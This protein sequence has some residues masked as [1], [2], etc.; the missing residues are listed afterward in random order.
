[1]ERDYM[2]VSKL[3][4]ATMK[5]AQITKIGV[6]ITMRS[7]ITDADLPTT[8]IPHFD[9]LTAAKRP[10]PGNTYFCTTATNV[11]V[12]IEHDEEYRWA[13]TFGASHTDDSRDIPEAIWAC[14]P[15]HSVPEEDIITI[16]EP[17]D[18][19]YGVRPPEGSAKIF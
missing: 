1:M 19:G 18:S 9:Y 14:Y 17:T 10:S 13:A 11:R 3:T 16:D 12:L 4:V 7:F 5:Q 6:P 8:V 15:G 2:I